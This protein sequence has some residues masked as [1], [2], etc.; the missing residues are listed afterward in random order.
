[1]WTTLRVYVEE[2]LWHILIG[3]DHML[4][5]LSLLLTTVLTARDGYWQP[6]ENFRSVMWRVLSIV[7]VFTLSHSVTLWL[8]VAGYV[9]LPSR[10]VETAI[11]LSVLIAAVLNLSPAKSVSRVW[12]TF[13]FGL[14]HG[15]GFANVLLDL[16]LSTFLLGVSLFG[17]NAGVE[18]GQLSLV[19]VVLPLAYV[20]RHTRFYRTFVVRLGSSIIAAVACI[21][22]AQRLFD[23]SIFEFAL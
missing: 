1:M 20:V 23:I 4:F 6:A 16:G 9:V 2:G 13:G 14:V 17:F 15:F 19:A 18:L 10:L 5:L 8:T 7:T 3:L 21:W 11:A 22:F 12:L